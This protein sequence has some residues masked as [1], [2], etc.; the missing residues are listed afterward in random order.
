MSN[1][2]GNT[3]RQDQWKP[4]STA[5]ILYT[6]TTYGWLSRMLAK[7]NIK[8][9]A[10][11]PRKIFSYLPTVKDALGLR[12]SGIY[13]IPCECGRA[14]IGQSG[15]S[16]QIWIKEHERLIRLAQPDKSPVAEHSVNHDHIIKREDTKLLSVKTRYMDW[17]IREATELEMHPHNINR[18]DGLTLR[19]SWK[20]HSTQ[21]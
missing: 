2:T 9:V 21:D 1:G 6:Q 16:I 4:T 10:L 14:Y 3:D 12:T 11:P 5:Y 13:S 8:S 7:H 17:L 19:K 20:P 15:Q 18:E